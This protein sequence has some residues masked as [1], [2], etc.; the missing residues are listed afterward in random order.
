MDELHQKMFEWSSLDKEIKNLNNK[1][2]ALRKKKEKLQNELFPIIK[3]NNLEDN[4]FSI[5]SLNMEVSL[6]EQKVSESIS[7]KF[8]EEKF[9]NYFNNFE[10]CQK[11]LQYIKDNR[12]KDTTMLL[13]S[14]PTKKDNGM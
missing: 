9:S 1:A 7:Y 8:L 4:I 2:S 11:L 14:N 12:K 6:K 10:E 5:P 3:Q 13:K